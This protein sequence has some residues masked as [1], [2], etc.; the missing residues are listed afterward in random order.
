MRKGIILAACLALLIPALSLAGET[1]YGKGVSSREATLPVSEL[2][3]NPDA[4]VGQTVRV[5]GLVVGV[6]EHRGCWINIASDKEG[7]SV[8]VKVEDGV[9]VFPAN[10]LGSTVIAEGVWTSNKLDL[11]TTK[12][13]CEHKAKEAGET[14]NPDTV[15]DCMTLYQISGTGAVTLESA[16]TPKPADGEKRTLEADKPQHKG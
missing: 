15:T 3:A 5:Q 1:V 4:H 2:I 10:I 6:C 7:E 12:K 13:V 9:I 11:E 16:A 8:R 14:F